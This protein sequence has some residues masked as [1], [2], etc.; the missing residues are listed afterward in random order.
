MREYGK[1]QHRF[2]TDTVN[3]TLSPEA[4]II[5]CYLMTGEHSNAIGLFRLPIGYI[6]EDLSPWLPDAETV[7]KGF[8]ELIATGQIQ[9]AKGSKTVLITN[10]MRHNIVENPNVEKLC[11]KLIDEVAMEPDN[12]QLFQALFDTVD[13]KNIKNTD[14]FL[15]RLSEVIETLS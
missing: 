11:L 15:N 7:S 13:G 14:R 6:V 1:L 10:F 4:L 8:D 9:Y 2:W 5:F 3:Q 12:L